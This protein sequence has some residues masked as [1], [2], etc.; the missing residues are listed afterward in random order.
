MAQEAAW[1][2]ASSPVFA[3]GSLGVGDG[4]IIL[5]QQRRS[6]SAGHMAKKDRRPRSW[7][8]KEHGSAEAEE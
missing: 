3:Q 1:S 2:W 4:V 6:R 8:K 5:G 7:N